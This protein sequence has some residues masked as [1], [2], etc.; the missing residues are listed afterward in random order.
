MALLGR[1]AEVPVP[2]P[3]FHNMPNRARHAALPSPYCSW[4][5]LGQQLSWRLRISMYA[6][7]SCI[8][9]KVKQGSRRGA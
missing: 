7:P 8:P 5:I 1:Y 9:S 3:L 4:Q 2:H 6:P